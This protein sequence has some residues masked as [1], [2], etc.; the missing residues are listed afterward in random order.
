MVVVPSSVLDNWDSELKK[1]CPSLNT[2][3]Y[4]GS[5]KE[6]AKMRQSLN[7]VSSG[8]AREGMPVRDLGISSWGRCTSDRC[9]KQSK[10][11]I[12]GRTDCES[13]P[14]RKGWLNL[15]GCHTHPRMFEGHPRSFFPAN[16]RLGGHSRI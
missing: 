15:R 4:H 11:F 13:S 7:A 8:A 14:A 16:H 1:F 6:R 9:Q 2:V 12:E 5:Q 3:K 10:R